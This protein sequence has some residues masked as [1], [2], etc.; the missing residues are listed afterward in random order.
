MCGINKCQLCP[1]MTPWCLSNLSQEQK[2]PEPGWHDPGQLRLGSVTGL[3]AGAFP[4][5]AV[6]VAPAG[7]G[8]LECPM[9]KPAKW[10]L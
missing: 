5:P 8:F 2:S 10:S 7:E 6:C 3:L 9:I 4:E 1:A